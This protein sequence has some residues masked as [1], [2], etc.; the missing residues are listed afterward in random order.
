MKNL[1]KIL[2]LTFLLTFGI[3]TGHT[4]TKVNFQ[5][6]QPTETTVYITKT[7]TKYHLA[8]CRYL[9]KSKI[10]IDKS[11]AIKRGYTACKVCKP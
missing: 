8:T 9:S 10:A 7:G 1:L 4:E 11:E 3:A 6:V 2:S 5:Q